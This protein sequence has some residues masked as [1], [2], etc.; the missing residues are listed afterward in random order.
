MRLFLL[1]N[2]VFT[3]VSYFV[4]RHIAPSAYVPPP[5]KM[6]K[7]AKPKV[8]VS[9]LWSWAD[10]QKV[11]V[12]CACHLV[13]LCSTSASTA[14]ASNLDRARRISSSLRSDTARAFLRRERTAL[15]LAARLA[16]PANHADSEQL[17]FLTIQR[18]CSCGRAWFLNA[19]CWESPVV[20]VT[21]VWFQRGLKRVV[22]AAFVDHPARP[23]HMFSQVP[24][25][26]CARVCPGL[27]SSS[28]LLRAQLLSA[29]RWCQR[30]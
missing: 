9:L 25:H 12:E 28:L 24:C 30:R 22:S 6:K 3:L 1:V 29:R 14:A 8:S 15:M 7:R 17:T 5:E 21:L 19:H 2:S 13:G 11:R 26:G 23:A 10:M 18:R 16:S 20:D 4:A 27:R